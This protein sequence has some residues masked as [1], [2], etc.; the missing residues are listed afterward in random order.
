MLLLKHIK[1]NQKEG[2]RYKELED[3]L[4]SLSRG[5][6]RGLLKELQKEGRI[7]HMGTTRAALWFPGPP[8]S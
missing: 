1:D 3:V 8:P 7:H 6:M 2:T 5:Q 4:P